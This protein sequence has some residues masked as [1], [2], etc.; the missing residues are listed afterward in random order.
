MQLVDFWGEAFRVP[1][2]REQSLIKV[3]D[4]RPLF[5]LF[6]LPSA[7]TD[8]STRVLLTV[9]N[10]SWPS[11]LTEEQ[12]QALK[13]GQIATTSVPRPPVVT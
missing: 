12:K 9:T 2:L 8:S 13:R 10:M 11:S 7:I 6:L 3:I 5:L 1:T 4:S